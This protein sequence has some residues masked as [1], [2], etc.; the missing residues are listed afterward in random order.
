MQIAK[1]PLSLTIIALYLIIGG[2]LNLI[3]VPMTLIQ[4]RFTYDYSF[5]HVTPLTIS[6][7]IFQ[8][9]IGVLV[10]ILILKRFLWG[11]WVYAVT[12]PVLVTISSVI[13][14]M[15]WLQIFTVVTG[16][17]FY[18]VVLFFLFRPAASAYF[19]RQEVKAVD[20][21]P[22]VTAPPVTAS[23]R[24][25]MKPVKLGRRIVAL[26]VFVT[27]V[28]IVGAMII[29]ISI[30]I[31]LGQGTGGV[32]ALLVAL[33]F[34]VGFFLAGLAL[35]DWSRWRVVSVVMLCAIGI[36]TLFG[37]AAFAIMPYLPIFDTTMGQ[38][39]PDF[40]NMPAISGLVGISLT[41]L[42]V[43][44]IFKQRRMDHRVAPV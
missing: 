18:F 28:M 30:V 42:G 40:G 6:I 17:I 43:L 13:S 16:G 9:L 27:S 31:S 21:T 44:A 39:K 25:P 24:L 29:A 33:L 15:H 22:F 38:N 19:H 20:N 11:R 34:G 37:A 1:R 32:I 2:G 10:G 4:P 36:Y 3:T 8:S 26:L 23:P 5:F 41:G 7:G 35:W 12:I 14:G